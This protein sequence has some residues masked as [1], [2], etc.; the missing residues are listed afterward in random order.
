MINFLKKIN[1]W[2]IFFIITLII[3][4]ILYYFDYKFNWFKK[5]KNYNEMLKY[6]I[7][8]NSLLNATIIFIILKYINI[9]ELRIEHKLNNLILNNKPFC[10]TE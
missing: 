10:Y 2:T 4:V 1:I 7:I 6:R 9:D 5:W 3:S 8:K